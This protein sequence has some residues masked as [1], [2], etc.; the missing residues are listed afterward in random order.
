MKNDSDFKRIDTPSG[1]SREVVHFFWNDTRLPAREG[2]TIAAALLAAGV[3][4][5]RETLVSHSPR[6]PFCMMGSCFECRVTVNGTPNVQ[7]CMTLVENGM[8]VQ[9]GRC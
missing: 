7:A 4:T 1:S 9:S 6:A 8:T 5:T 2:D 3:S